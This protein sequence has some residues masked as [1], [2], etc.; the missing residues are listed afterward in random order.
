MER[1]LIAYKD[2][3][4]RQL[5]NFIKN[6]RDIKDVEIVADYLA[7]IV[8]YSDTKGGYWNETNIVNFLLREVEEKLISL[9]D[10]K[11]ALR[12]SE[13]G[14][15]GI[16]TTLSKQIKEEIKHVEQMIFV[17]NQVLFIY[18]EVA[19]L[20][21]LEALRGYTDKDLGKSE[22]SALLQ[23]FRAI[24]KRNSIYGDGVRSLSSWLGYFSENNDLYYVYSKEP[25][26]KWCTLNLAFAEVKKQGAGV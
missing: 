23:E 11:G 12:R 19:D 4:G 10:L 25:D 20:V 2:Y 14:L 1:L 6:T 8:K 3:N 22:Q 26:A 9:D 24:Y 15:H 16:N 17:Y 21:M 18:D 7:K 5:Q 13:L